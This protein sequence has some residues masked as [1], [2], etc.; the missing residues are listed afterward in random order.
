MMHYF[1]IK[2]HILPQKYKLYEPYQTIV[3]YNV[4]KGRNFDATEVLPVWR[5]FSPNKE[6]VYTDGIGNYA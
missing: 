2:L 5:V 6:T 1:D 4:A 3:N